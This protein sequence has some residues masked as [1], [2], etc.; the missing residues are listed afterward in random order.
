MITPLRLFLVALIAL[1]PGWASAFRS[2]TR[3][4]VNP[5]SDGVWEVV[6]RPGTSAS[7]YWCSAGDFA[8]RQLGAAATQRVYLWR[9][10]GPSATQSGKAAVQFS[11]SAPAGANTTPGYSLSVK[12]VGDNLTAAAAQQYCYGRRLIDP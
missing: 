9:A 11:F 10:L 3:N 5:V 4:E 6:Q 2:Q 7:D 1:T 12:A 8:I